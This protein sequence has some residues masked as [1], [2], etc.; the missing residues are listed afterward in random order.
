[1]D[2]FGFHVYPADL[3]LMALTVIGYI[4]MQDGHGI[5]IIRGDGLPFTM[6]AGFMIPGMVGYGFPITNG[7]P[8][9]FAGEDPQVIT[10]GRR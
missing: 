3:L 6:V 5:L 7:V 2:T 8:D 10:D 9:G 1:M 4:H